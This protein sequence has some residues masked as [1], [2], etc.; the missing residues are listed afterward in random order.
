MVTVGAVVGAG[1]LGLAVGLAVAAGR[2]RRWRR[3]GRTLLHNHQ[4]LW[5]RRPDWVHVEGEDLE[6]WREPVASAIAAELA[7]LGFAR[8]GYIED[9]AAAGEQRL[10]T[11]FLRDG[12][13][14]HAASSEQGG[15]DVLEF[16][17]ELEDGTVLGTINLGGTMLLASPPGIDVAVRPGTDA[18]ALLRAHLERLQ[19][20]LASGA[21]V[22]RM[23]TIA[24]VIASQYRQH[25]I[26]RTFR[27]GLGYVS[28]DE[29][30]RIA[31]TLRL[32]PEARRHARASY[33]DASRAGGD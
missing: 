29:W 17:T 32:S 26:T 25:E 14:V 22:R 19:G 1:M 8:I 21:A 33:R 15:R 3:L 18:P 20:R 4:A 13:E 7:A 30:E 28:D 11:V 24:D 27:M 10:L 12:G 23:S 9:A 31:D 2:R 5:T 16:E 6:P